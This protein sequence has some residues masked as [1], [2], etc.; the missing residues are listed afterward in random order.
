MT[1]P[2]LIYVEVPQNSLLSL[3]T[4]KIL[5]NFHGMAFGGVFK[6]DLYANI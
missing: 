2:L 5:L 1:H 6:G 3:D 4:N